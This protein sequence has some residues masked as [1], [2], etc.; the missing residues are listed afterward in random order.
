MRSHRRPRTA[1][2]DPTEASTGRFADQLWSALMP[3]RQSSSP[4]RGLPLARVVAPGRTPVAYCVV[5][6]ID[7]RGRFADRSPLQV[8]QWRS[9]LPVA[10][11]VLP[12][13]VVIVPHRNGRHAITRQGYLRLPA[14]VR[15]VCRLEAGDRLLLV[16]CSDRDLL[17]AYTMA[18][19]EAMLLAYHT[20]IPG[21]AAP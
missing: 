4:A 8:L 9:G 3:E 1:A 10:M 17:V 5:T 16:A 18:A 2:A 7:D 11:C 20:A 19:L 6:P 21:E 14:C 15:H 12:G 13:A